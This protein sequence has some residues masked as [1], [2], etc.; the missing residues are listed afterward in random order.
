MVGSRIGL[1]QGIHIQPEK[2]LVTGRASPLHSIQPSS[3]LLQYLAHIIALMD[4]AFWLV[5]YQ[6]S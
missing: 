2:Y 1:Q 5:H 4:G 3:N 6:V